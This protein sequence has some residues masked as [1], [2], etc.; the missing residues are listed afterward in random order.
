MT[1]NSDKL[2]VN[3]EFDPS[4]FNSKPYRAAAK[5]LMKQLIHRNKKG[6]QR[7]QNVSAVAEL[8]NFSQ[9]GDNDTTHTAA[10]TIRDYSEAHS[11]KLAPIVSLP[12]RSDLL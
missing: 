8:D 2:E 9:F 10:S 11:L 1:E 7:Q 6:R 4:V 3:F 5:S 12:S